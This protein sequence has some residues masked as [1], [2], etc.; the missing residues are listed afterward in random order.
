MDT[1]LLSV[2]SDGI[3]LGAILRCAGEIDL[4]N[5]EEFRR[6]LARSTWMSLPEV[7]VDL[8]R[9]TFMDSSAIAALLQ[10]QRELARRNGQLMV[11]AGPHSAHLFRLLGLDDILRL[12][13]VP[14]AEWVPVELA[15]HA[16][17][18]GASPL[19]EESR[20]GAAV[21]TLTS[22]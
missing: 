20:S 11:R 16:G 9:I 5:V 6:A 12:T 22:G 13:E 19:P 3:P 15:D 2:E 21:G 8:V 17:P 18:G 4:A 14:I 10:A 7:E 1:R